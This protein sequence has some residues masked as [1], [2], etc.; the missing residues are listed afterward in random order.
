MKVFSIIRI[1]IF[2]Q[3]TTHEKK[4]PF[5]TY[6]IFFSRPVFI[7]ISK[8]LIPKPA[9][10]VFKKK[11]KQIGVKNW[12]KL[13]SSSYIPL[14]RPPPPPPPHNSSPP[15]AVVRRGISGLATSGHRSLSP[16]VERAKMTN[17]RADLVWLTVTK[18]LL[19][20]F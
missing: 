17:T 3:T 5:H 10:L 14:V 11:Q 8:V 9:V 12:N 20:Y 19:H 15:T 2:T 16:P 7:R 18:Q 4:K 6:R 13:A 1:I